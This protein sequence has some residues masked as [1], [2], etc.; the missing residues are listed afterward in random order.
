MLSSKLPK[1]NPTAPI[2]VSFPDAGLEVAVKETL[3]K[4]DADYLPIQ[5][6]S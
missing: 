3:G 6:K 1:Q 2:I 5:E 4:A